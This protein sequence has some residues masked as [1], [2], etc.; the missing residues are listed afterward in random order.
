MSDPG[1]LSQRLWEDSEPLVLLSLY[2]PFVRG[3][4][5]WHTSE[6]KAALPLCAHWVPIEF[7]GPLMCHRSA[8][9]LRH[10]ELND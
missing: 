10:E 7:P 6:V 2:H 3:D 9:D 4:R 8:S 5:T 1:K